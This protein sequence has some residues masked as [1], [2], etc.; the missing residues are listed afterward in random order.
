M[1]LH[2]YKTLRIGPLNVTLSRSGLSYSIGNKYARV[3]KR[4][5][6]S[7]RTSIKMPGGWRFKKG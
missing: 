7:R 4:S 6:G 3:G 5:N 2:F 1:P